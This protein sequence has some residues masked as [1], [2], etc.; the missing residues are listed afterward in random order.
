II[1]NS[2]L[3]PME[4][5]EF[6]KILGE[7]K[8]CFWSAWLG[9]VFIGM[10][11]VFV[12]PDR[13]EA[14]LSFDIARE[15]GGQNIQEYQYDQYYR[16]EAD[17]RFAKTV[18][19]WLKD[20]NIQRQIAENASGEISDKHIQRSIRSL[21]AEKKSANFVQARFIVDDPNEAPIIARSIKNVLDKRTSSLNNGAKDEK[22]FK[23]IATGPSISKKNLPFPIVLPFSVIL[24]LLMAVFAVLVLHY[25]KE[26]EKRKENENRD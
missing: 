16:L 10:L 1:H 15:R 4:F 23:I 12:M 25:F 13:T 22:W 9:I 6:L 17:D 19:Q 14:V 2:K 26:D 7:R 3:I 11:V 24:G 5:R 21:R 8:K 20:P 18:A